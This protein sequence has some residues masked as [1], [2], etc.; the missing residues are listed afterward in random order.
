MP[1][2]RIHARDIDAALLSATSAHYQANRDTWKVLG[3]C[4]LDGD[5]LAVVVAVEEE[6]VR[7]RIVTVF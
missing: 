1:N 6:M 3:G 5:A 4:D 7:V 2:R